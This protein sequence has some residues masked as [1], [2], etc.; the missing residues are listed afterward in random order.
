MPF[1]V[2]RATALALGLLVWFVFWVTLILQGF[3]VL[4][5]GPVRL[6]ELT[7]FAGKDPAS[8]RR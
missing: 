4:R 7:G 1:G 5:G 6:A 2:D 3:L 8:D